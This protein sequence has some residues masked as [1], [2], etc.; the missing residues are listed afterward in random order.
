M[1]GCKTDQVNGGRGDE[2]M[3]GRGGGGDVGEETGELEGEEL[4]KAHKR[5]V[6]ACLPNNAGMVS[7]PWLDGL[8]GCKGKRGGGHKHAHI[9]PQK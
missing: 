7:Q 5:V 9:P 6:A 3:R 8:L 1:E 4:R 2:A